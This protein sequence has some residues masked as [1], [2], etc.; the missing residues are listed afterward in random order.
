M[1]EILDVIRRYVPAGTVVTVTQLIRDYHIHLHIRRDRRSR[2]GDYRAPLPNDPKHKISVNHNLNPYAFLIT[3]IHELAHRKV[4][5]ETSYAARP[6]GKEWKQAFRE[7]MKPFLNEDVFPCRLLEV[8]KAY[9]K[10][11]AA[12]S[13]S[14]ERLSR[15]LRMY[16]LHKEEETLLEN[17]E[18]G[19]LFSLGDSRIF[20]KGQLQ[21]KRYLCE[22]ITNKKHYYVNRIE[23]VKKH[24]KQ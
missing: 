18:T 19:S 23:V 2:A 8:V 22:C 3:F 11:P 17:L 14:D 1:D 9:L 7:L 24:T 16:D 20:R 5:E 21:R 15:A 4:Y 6:H 12:S 10:D 13:Y